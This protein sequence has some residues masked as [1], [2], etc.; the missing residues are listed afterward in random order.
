[1]EMIKKSIHIILF[2]I[3]VIAVYFISERHFFRIDL[4]S[5]KRYSLSDNTKNLL[6]SLDEELEVKVY[7]DGDLNAGFLRLR[8]ATKEM[9]DEFDAYAGKRVRYSF[10]NPS[11]GAT[12]E[13]RD[14]KY[15][16]LEKRGM[17]GILVH[18]R[19]QEGQAMQKVVFPWIEI[20]YKGKSRP[21]N[22]LKNV[23]DKSG[24]ENLNTSIETLEYE[25]TDALRLMTTK[26][27]PKVAFLEGHGE[28]VQPLVYDMTQALSHYYQ[29]DRGAIT[30]DPSI[31]N[32]YKALIIAGPT[33][34]FPE[35]DK[36]VID[37]YI[38]KGGK[39][40]WL[41]DGA[42]ISLDSLST[43]SQT[44]GIENKLNL[45]DQLF[46]YGVRI[47]ADLVQD[48][49]C[50][51]IPVNT[52]RMGDQPKY[53]PMPWY[54][55]PLALATPIHPI[56]KNLAPVK[57]EFVSS[58]DFVNEEMDVKKTPL[59]VTSTGTHVQNIPSVV[60]MD[61][62]NVEKNGYYFNKHNIILGAVLEGVFPSVF[63][64][65]MVPQGVTTS[66]PMLTE[67]KPTKMVV[68][69]DGDVIRNDV[70]GKGENM[71]ILPLGYDRYM[72]QQFSNKELLL[73]AVNYL[74]DD[75]GWMALRSREI[76]LRLLNKPAIIGQRTFWQIANIALPLVLLGL[77]G[78][79][80]N[81]IRKKRYTKELKK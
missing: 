59:L 11:A 18:D 12:N 3:A 32:D 7:L 38:M 65:R 44:I 10:E 40:L 61:V 67:S 58:I 22:L 23:P 60:S 20:I 26:Q 2:I 55:S 50:L 31:L 4:T 16:E 80:F 24:E 47:N 21:V 13:E 68:I 46:N 9:L 70:Q 6:G 34:D 71:N 51:L 27:V 52:A 57:T 81:F 14:K 8:K 49:Q 39:V 77:F 19:D 45:S 69:A 63:K 73:N 28:W 48:V 33:E 37:Q 25:I 1:M 36:Y 54:Y 42:R 43:A 74:T 17:R 56:S 72:N 29:V 30:D 41:V 79:C 5:E 78:V 66:D 35:K 64:N 53:E 75:D 76:K 15:E 62:I